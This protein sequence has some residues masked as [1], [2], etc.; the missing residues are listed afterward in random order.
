MM[1]VA[2]GVLSDDVF[3]PS[4]ALT[5]TVTRFDRRLASPCQEDCAL[6]HESHLLVTRS[7]HRSFDTSLY[8]LPHP[9]LDSPPRGLRSAPARL[10]PILVAAH[11]QRLGS[12]LLRI[13]SYQGNY[14]ESRIENG[15]IE[16]PWTYAHLDELCTQVP[17]SR[18][19]APPVLPA[20]DS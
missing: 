2:V 16:V 13:L 1:A 3:P 5:I 11:K 6:R 8:Q 10:M 14:G 9:G 7:P 12:Q 15:F 20:D 4:H 19:R 17:P 18:R